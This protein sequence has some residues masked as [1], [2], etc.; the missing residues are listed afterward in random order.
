MRRASPLLL[1]AVFLAS[2]PF[3]ILATDPPPPVITNLN[4]SGKQ[5]GLRFEPYPAASN[6]TIL[7][8]TDAASPLTPNTNFF[9][10]PFIVSSSTNGTNYSYEW[11]ITNN[12]APSGLYRV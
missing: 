9:L 12:T 11:R 8:G 6:Y 1:V 10:A 3:T 4:I 2:F 5:V 7:S